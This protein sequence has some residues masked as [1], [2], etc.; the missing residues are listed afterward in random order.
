MAQI[1]G[2]QMVAS[3]P[4]GSSTLSPLAHPGLPHSL[5]TFQAL[6]LTLGVLL[7]VLDTVAGYPLAMQQFAQQYFSSSSFRLTSV[8]GVIT[9]IT[10][11]LNAVVG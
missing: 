9:I 2:L 7:S 4:S 10:H 3:H 11:L 5:S 6:Y 8:L 1:A